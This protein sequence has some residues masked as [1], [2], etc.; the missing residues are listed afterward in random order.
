MKMPTS[1][2]TETFVQTPSALRIPVPRS[3]SVSPGHLAWSRGLSTSQSAHHFM[4][5]SLD[6]GHLSRQHK[7]HLTS[8]FV[9][10]S[11]LLTT[12]LYHH[13]IFSRHPLAPLRLQKQ[14]FGLHPNLLSPPICFI[15]YE[16]RALCAVL[17]LVIS[18]WVAVR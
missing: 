14:A 15:L 16:Y 13:R 8:H 4:Y 2:S 6:H 5:I 17:L 7:I 10:C 1:S 9:S 18:G 3:T 11:L 12:S